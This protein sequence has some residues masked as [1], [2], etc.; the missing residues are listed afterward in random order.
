MDGNNLR[1][2]L[3]PANDEVPERVYASVARY[4]GLLAVPARLKILRAVCHSERSVGDVVAAT[5]LSQTGVSRHLALLHQAG[6]V[7]RR[8]AG[9]M[10]FYQTSDPAF[11]DICRLMCTRIAGRIESGRPLRE[12]L[13]DFAA[14][15]PVAGARFTSRGEGRRTRPRHSRSPL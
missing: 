2:P 4:F 3:R 6:V 8:K 11:I 9:N 13:L 7:D 14:A 15:H 1:K 10:A 12:E 5:G